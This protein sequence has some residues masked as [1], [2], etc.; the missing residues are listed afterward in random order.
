MTGP[1]LVYA[2]DAAFYAQALRERFPAWEVRTAGSRGEALAHLPGCEALVAPGPRVDDAMLALAPGLRWV[3]AITSGVDTLLASRQ[4][5]ED[6]IVTS[7]RGI[8]GPQMAELALLLMLALPRQLPRMLANQASGAWERWPQPLLQG[9]HAVLLGMGHV[10]E[11]LAQRCKAMGMRVTAMVSSQRSVPHCDAVRTRGELLQAVADADFVVV[12]LPRDESTVGL[13]GSEV[14]AAMPQHS[15]LL[16]LGRGGVVDEQALLATLQEQR[17]AG[18]GL[19]VFQTEPLPSAN[20]LWSLP[21]VILTPHIGGHSDV[22]AQQALPLLL[23]NAQAWSSG[24]P[25][26]LQNRVR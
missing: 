1:V 2:D 5:A 26:E 9:R 17:I 18:A 23:A 22:Y 20:P 8:H 14:L 10:G 12:L 11:A 16:N 7:S 24:R 3:H 19:D 21:N 13:V 4:L 15:Y 6:A 25:G